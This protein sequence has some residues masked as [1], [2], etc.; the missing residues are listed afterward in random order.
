MIL[1]NLEDEFVDI[2]CHIDPTHIPNMLY[3]KRKK[4]IYLLFLEGTIRLYGILPFMVWYLSFQA[5]GFGFWTKSLWQMFFQKDGES[6][7]VNHL[8]L[9]GWQQGIPFKG[10]IMWGIFFQSG[11][12][13]WVIKYST[14]KEVRFYWHGYW[15]DRQ[16]EIKYWNAVI[17][18]ESIEMLDWDVSTPI[19][20][21]KCGNFTKIQ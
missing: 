3:E 15:D 20:Y 9:C 5:N 6:K 4:F 2:M 11:W 17:Y 13:L 7:T 12:T 19:A 14:W 16:W 8:L 10:W 21:S 1:I 18:Q